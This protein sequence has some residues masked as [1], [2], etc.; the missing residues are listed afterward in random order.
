M[1]LRRMLPISGRR[2][3]TFVAGRSMGGYGAMLL[4][5]NHPERFAC[6][7][8]ISGALDVYQMIRTHEWPEW[9]W[10]FGGDERY[11]GSDG[12]LVHM[13]DMVKGQKPR[14]FACCGLEDGLMEQNRVFVDKARAL[15]FDTTFLTEH[16]GHDWHY[17]NAMMTRALDWF[18]GNRS[19]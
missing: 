17:G 16:G 14:L 7:A 9:A 4:A 10:I 5:L 2:E 19:L 13:L 12:D 8:S 6:A 15:G 18:A 3:D 1:K 11:L